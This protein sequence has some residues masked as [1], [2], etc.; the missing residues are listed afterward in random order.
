MVTKEK[1]EELALFLE[2]RRRE[3][4]KERSNLVAGFPVTMDAPLGIK[5]GIPPLTQTGP[6]RRTAAEKFLDSENDKSDYDWLITPPGTP[7]VPS[8]TEMD[9][10]KTARPTALKSRVRTL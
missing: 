6:Q 2:L 10:Q 9:T 5:G 8:T 3:K 7:L 4:E 1:D